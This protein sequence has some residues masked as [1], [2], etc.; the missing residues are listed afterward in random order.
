MQGQASSTHDDMA[1]NV[2]DNACFCFAFRCTGLDQLEEVWW[3]HF[4]TS[5]FSDPEKK[6]ALL[7]G[8]STSWIF[9]QIQSC[10]L[11]TADCFAP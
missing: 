7:L 5:W 11:S 2:F 10:K 9:T 8:P 1:T 3:Q 4:C 6:W